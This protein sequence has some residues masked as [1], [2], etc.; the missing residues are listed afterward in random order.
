MT[1]G[2]APL[3]KVR[4]NAL[5]G[6]VG[7][8]MEWYDFAVYAYMAPV[9]SQLFFP[10]GDHFAS[11]LATYG[12]FAA[13]YLSRSLGALAFGHIGDK[14]GRKLVL[15]T[16]VSLMGVS[17][18][19]IGFLP[20]ASQIGPLAAVLLVLLRILQGFSVGGE[21]TGS[22]AFIVEYAPA[23]RRA[24]Y[25]SWVLCGSF[26][27][28]LLGSASATLLNN[29]FD[30]SELQNWAWRLP[31]LAGA[32]I[33]VAALVLRRH[34]EE[35]PAPNYMEEWERSPVVIA[36]T[37]YWRDILK[38]IGLS[39]SINVGFYMM[40]VYAT[41]YLTRR[42]HVSTAAA[43]DINTF[44]MTI[45]TVLPLAFALLSDRIGRKPI[46]LSGTIGTIVFSWPLFWLMHH[47]N[48]TL[49]LLGQLGFAVL[50]S[51]A[52]APNPAA[53]AEILPHRVRVSVLS[54]GY[55]VSLSVFG[56][57]TPLVAAYLVKR[58]ADDFAPVYYLMA[59]AVFSLIAVL[60]IPETK[61][62]SMME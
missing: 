13:G 11:L 49:V 19:A 22:T 47:A 51:W 44:C 20:N 54:I 29:L 23:K 55:N 18:V 10:S 6:A 58:T 24:F 41:D 21:Y 42:M 12:A 2:T 40:F 35:P 30:Q 45:I 33:A 48:P 43:M 53:L 39:L 38:V 26:G 27:G 7:N 52:Y 5:A 17:T 1:D 50:F 31:F 16:S 25:A 57:T 37:D 32:L 56:G 9:I 60:L 34:I 8:V 61:G 36:F 4:T 15:V 62:K 14:V 59:L 46:L 28:F 3:E